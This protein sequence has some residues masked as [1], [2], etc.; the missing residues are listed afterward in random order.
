MNFD[1]KNFFIGLMDFFSIIRPAH[2]LL[3]VSLIA[4]SNLADGQRYT[5][6]LQR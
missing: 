4:M 6:D 5:C 3:L 2:L 1:P